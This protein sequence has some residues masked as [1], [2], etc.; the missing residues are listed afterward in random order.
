MT[1]RDARISGC[2]ARI[3]RISFSGELAYEVNTSGWYGLAAWE[4]LLEAGR[5]IGVMPYG[6]ET[7]RIL[8]AEK[9]YPII[10]QETD[11]TVT[12]FDLGMD[13]I[14]SRKKDFIATR[15]YARADTRRAVRKQLVGLV[16]VDGATMLV[17]GAQLVAG[18]ASLHEL[19][20]PLIGHVTSAY[21]SVTLGTP[22][23]LALLS[24][25]AS[26]HGEV[27]QA[28][29]AMTSVAVRVTSPVLYDPE[30]KRRDGD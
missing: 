20:V 9:G 27:I 7:L 14:V 23:A 2:A 22:F 15:S 3:M 30:G 21:E 24:G 8:R 18:D 4:A 1:W 28:V 10:G 19:P 13:R 26:R 25:G 12:P 5:S 17:E 29:D 6:T 16:P 11:G